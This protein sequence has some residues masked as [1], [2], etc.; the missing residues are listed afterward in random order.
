MNEK[1]IREFAKQARMFNPDWNKDWY[2]ANQDQ[3]NKFVNLIEEHVLKDV[4]ND[5]NLSNSWE[6]N[7]DR[8]GGQFTHEE[9]HR[10]NERS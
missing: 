3:I 8:T 6:T 2:E 7:P 1:L 9:I 5:K 10:N 4:N